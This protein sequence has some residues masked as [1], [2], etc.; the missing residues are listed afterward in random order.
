[1]LCAFATIDSSSPETVF[2]GFR[3]TTNCE[4]PT[5]DGF[6]HEEEY[7]IRPGWVEGSVKLLLRNG[8]IVTVY[9]VS[10]R[11]LHD[12]AFSEMKEAVPRIIEEVLHELS[13]YV[14]VPCYSELPMHIR[15]RMEEMLKEGR[16]W[17]EIREE[18]EK[19][20]K[21]EREKRA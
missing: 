3:F 10:L 12:E 19:L 9:S 21:L 11:A 20:L 16:S 18:V 1:V 5:I 6:C 2:K 15:W 13:P 4:H 17:L 8:E 14:Y 7:E